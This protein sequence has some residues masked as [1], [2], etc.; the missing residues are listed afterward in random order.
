MRQLSLKIDGVHL[1]RALTAVGY[2]PRAKKSCPRKLV[3]DA[4]WKAAK[5]EGLTIGSLVTLQV[6]D[7]AGG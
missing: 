5:V 3:L 1:L 6:N 7:P 4:S 2:R